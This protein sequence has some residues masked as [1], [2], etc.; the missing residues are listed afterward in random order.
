[1]L[2]RV[3]IPKINYDVSSHGAAFLVKTYVSNRKQK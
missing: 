2:E 1:M 3:K